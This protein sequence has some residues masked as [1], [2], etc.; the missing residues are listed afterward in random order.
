MPVKIWRCFSCGAEFK[1]PVEKEEI[2]N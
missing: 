2:Q 1:E